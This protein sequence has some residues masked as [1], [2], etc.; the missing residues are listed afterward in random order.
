MQFNL[1][2]KK[3]TNLC[4]IPGAILKH[5]RDKRLICL[6]RIICKVSDWHYL[7]KLLYATSWGCTRHSRGSPVPRL[8]KTVFTQGDLSQKE[9]CP[10]PLPEVKYWNILAERFRHYLCTDIINWCQ[11]FVLLLVLWQYKLR[12]SFSRLLTLAFQAVFAGPFVFCI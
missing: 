2:K 7:S 12:S 6:F 11:A 10:R 4:H 3:T 1:K 9:L 5:Y 8:G